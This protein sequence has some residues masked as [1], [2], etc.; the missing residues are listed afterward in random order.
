MNTLGYNIPRNILQC[1]T[2]GCISIGDIRN[3]YSCPLRKALKNL[4]LEYRKDGNITFERDLRTRI[5]RG[6]GGK[7]ESGWN[8]VRIISYSKL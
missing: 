3:T 4:Y 2:I 6:G 7:L 8:S 1:A 5:P